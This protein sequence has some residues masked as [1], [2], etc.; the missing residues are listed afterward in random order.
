VALEQISEKLK[1]IKK[2]ATIT[3]KDE[4]VREKSYDPIERG[5]SL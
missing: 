1:M 2:D 3:K 5:I 4:L